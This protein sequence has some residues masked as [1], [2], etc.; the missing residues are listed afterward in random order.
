V[1]TERVERLRA[2]LPEPPWEREAR[3]AAAGV[4]RDVIRYL[5]RRGGAALVDRVVSESGADLRWAAFFF[6]EKVKGLRRQGVPLD[7]VTPERWC[8]L[9]GAFAGRPTLRE[10]WR[11]LSERLARRPEAGMDELLEEL[12][13][14]GEAPPWRERLPVWLERAESEAYDDD[15]GRIARH[16][17]GHAMRSLRG[18]VPGAEVVDAVRR[19]L[20]LAR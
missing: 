12:G 10:A 2:A 4:P 5:V 8:E 13:L 6:G 16:A 19:S 7:A 20:E 17:A 9:F 14:A 3:Y 11:A 18:K 1:T 15:A